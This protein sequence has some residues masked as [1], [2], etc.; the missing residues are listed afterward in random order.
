MQVVMI[1]SGNVATVLGRKIVRAGHSVRQVF[2]RNAEHAVQLGSELGCEA[3]AEVAALDRTGELYIVAIADDALTG[4]GDWL[5]LD[6]QL[7]V[8]TAGTVSREVLEGVSTDYG[9][10]YPLQSLR[11]EIVRIPEIPFLTDGNHE[12]SRNRIM[13]FAE[14]LSPAVRYAGDVERRS[15]HLAAIIGN[16][17]TNH[18]YA[19]SEEFCNRESVDF[20]LLL[21]LLAETIAR[22]DHYPPAMLQ[23]GPAIRNDSRTIA[24]HMTIL[25]AYPAL[26]KLYVTITE[27]IQEFHRQR[28]V[29]SSSA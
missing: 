25:K 20:H 16:N 24:K 13:Q 18:L 11:R 14:T 10:L 21:P 9:V 17:F 27:N 5:S 3:V 29:G 6:K 19:L 1:G 12:M 26:E 4:V 8:H 7:V 23:T 15:L 22:L 2:S 28:S